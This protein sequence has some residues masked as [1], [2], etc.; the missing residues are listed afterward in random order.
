MLPG[1]ARH[2]QTCTEPAKDDD[3]AAAAGNRPRI[4]IVEDNWI[5]AAEIE[6]TLVEA[7]YHVIGIAMSAE[8]AVQL[9]SADRPDIVL[10]DIRLQ[11]RRDG[12]EAAIEL[13]DRYDIPSVFLTAHGE[14]ETRRRA[15]PARPLGWIVKPVTG[16]ALV[17][18][19]GEFLQAGP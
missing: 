11:G 1:L 18:Q 10:M 17:R 12:I 7:G 14:P 3:A 4:V 16:V 2:R 8:Q 6:V 5:I 19:L 15:E 9:C 13:R